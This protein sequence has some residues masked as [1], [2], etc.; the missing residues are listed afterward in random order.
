MPSY[1]VFVAPEPASPGDP[2]PDPT[3]ISAFLTTQDTER[4][5]VTFVIERGLL[6]V[7]A[8]G[9]VQVCDVTATHTYITTVDVSAEPK[10]PPAP[11]RID[12]IDPYA[13]AAGTV[14][15]LHGAGF[16][17]IGGVRFEGDSGTAWAASFEIVDDA[18]MTCPVP[19]GTGTVTVVAFDGDL[20]DAILPDG[21]MYA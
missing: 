1:I 7:M 16:T 19:P 10:V 5:A 4:Q 17:G 15:T 3:P 11:R 9:E 8:D 13:G 6:T 18:T 20:G 21:F 12:W 14:I 2:L